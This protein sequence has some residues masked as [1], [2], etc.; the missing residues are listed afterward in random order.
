VFHE[1][2]LF[3][4]VRAHAFISE[5]AHELLHPLLVLVPFLTLLLE[6]SHGQDPTASILA[7]V[8]IHRVDSCLGVAL[9]ELCEEVFLGDLMS[10]VEQFLRVYMRQPELISKRLL[11]GIKHLLLVA[12]PLSLIVVDRTVEHLPDEGVAVQAWKSP[13]WEQERRLDRPEILRNP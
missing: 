5:L 4:L 6:V 11:L 1:A 12:K 7:L 3:N 9:T 10:A 8:V 2:C 13:L